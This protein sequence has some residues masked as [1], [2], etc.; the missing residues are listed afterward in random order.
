MTKNQLTNDIRVEIL[1]EKEKWSSI[2]VARDNVNKKLWIALNYHNVRNVYNWIIDDIKE[3]KN[4]LSD[5]NETIEEHKHYEVTDDHYIFYSKRPNQETGEMEKVMFPIE[6]KVV[7]QI[8]KDF[9]KH[10]NNLSGEEIL[11]KYEIKPELFQMIKSRLRLYKAS[12]V[13]SPATL[14]RLSPE[15]QQ[16]YIDWAIDEHIKNRYKERFTKTHDKKLKEDYIRKSKILSNYDYL[17]EHLNEFLKNHKPREIELITSESKNNDRLLACISDMHLGKKRTA[18]VRERIF[19]ITQDLIK[20]PEQFV[21][22]YFWGD[23]METLARW[24]MHKGQL[25]SMD[26]PFEFDLLMKC[27]EEIETMLLSLYKSWKNVTV[28]WVWGNH[29]RF[30]QNKEDWMNWLWD[31][32]VYEMV[33]RSVEQIW[34]QINILRD[35]WNT[36][37]IDWIHYIAHHW[38]DNATKKKASEI[39]WEKGKQWVPNVILFGD[40]HHYEQFDPNSDAVKILI[41][42]IAWANEYD[43]KMLL[44]SYTWYVIIT[45]EDWVPCTYTRRFNTN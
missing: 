4:T 10:W 8:F 30:T 11:Q 45:K 41:P 25:E 3:I 12:D 40:K 14:D 21:D 19:K 5:L 26:W 37:D 42:S 44:A 7:D 15:E 34:I 24:W 18:N 39:L 36:F 17:L 31:L 32:L 33:R 22:L 20:R 9:S 23:N 28:Y 38:D 13:I 35:T 6:I 43:E 27:V 29:S 1:A 16:Q 2:R